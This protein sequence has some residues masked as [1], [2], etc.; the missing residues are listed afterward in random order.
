MHWGQHLGAIIYFQVSLPI[1]RVLVRAGFLL[2]AGLRKE[3]P[4]CP[5]SADPVLSLPREDSSTLKETLK[6]MGR[7]A[8]LR[9]CGV[10]RSLVLAQV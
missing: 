9:C 5:F 6:A 7:I 2:G 4:S 3:G 10:E 8:L 1:N